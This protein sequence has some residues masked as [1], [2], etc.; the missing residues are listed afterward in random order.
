MTLRS[1]SACVDAETE[2]YDQNPFLEYLMNC[3]DL[4]LAI[5]IFTYNIIL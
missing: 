2:H 1:S 5:T 4:T 3:L